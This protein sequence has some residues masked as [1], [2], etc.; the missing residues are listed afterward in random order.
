MGILDRLKGKTKAKQEADIINFS[1]EDEKNLE[2]EPIDTLNLGWY[3]S[4]N[5]DEFQMAK[6]AEKDY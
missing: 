3:F 2:L 6:I 4:E 1:Q 5:K